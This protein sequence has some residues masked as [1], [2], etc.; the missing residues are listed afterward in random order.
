M[1]KTER[2]NRS[3]LSIKSM[4]ANIPAPSKIER[5]NKPS[6]SEPA[7]LK[8]ERYNPLMSK[9]SSCTNNKT[10]IPTEKE[11]N[12]SSRVAG[13][14]RIAKASSIEKLS[15]RASTNNKID[16]LTLLDKF[17]KYFNNPLINPI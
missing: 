5:N 12:S 2:G 14:K 1:T 3:S 15:T 9:A 7:C 10:K 13:L 4:I 6:S 8:T 11:R 17:D 16:A